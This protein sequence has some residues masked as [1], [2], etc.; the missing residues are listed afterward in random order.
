MMNLKENRSESVFE[1][2]IDIL[3]DISKR[4]KFELSGGEQKL[5]IINKR[6]LELVNRENE[7]RI[8]EF[9]KNNPCHHKLR[10][11]YRQA[12]S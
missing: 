6:V 3:R 7:K 9:F 5:E 2:T 4:V 10:Q 1:R 12:A 11:R 8:I